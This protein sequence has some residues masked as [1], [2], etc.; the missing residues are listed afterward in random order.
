MKAIIG[1][2]VIE[3]LSPIRAFFGKQNNRDPFP[4]TI[5]S[6]IVSCK[7]HEQRH[8]IVKRGWEGKAS[9]FSFSGNS[10]KCR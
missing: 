9:Y 2:K 10:E 4:T 5:Q 3:I 8:K 7:K 1:D 6:L